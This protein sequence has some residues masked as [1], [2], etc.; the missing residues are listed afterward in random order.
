MF[1][2]VLIVEN[3]KR[4]ARTISKS[5]WLGGGGFFSGPQPFTIYSTLISPG[6]KKNRVNLI[7]PFSPLFCLLTI[8]QLV[9]LWTKALAYAM[10]ASE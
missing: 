10:L 1:N 4:R 8:G 9:G 5:G 7:K 6:R 2:C 3:P